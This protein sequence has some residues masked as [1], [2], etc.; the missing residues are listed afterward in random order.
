M[1]LLPIAYKWNRP[2]S[3]WTFAADIQNVT[4]HINP[5]FKE[6]NPNTDRI[7]QVSQIGIVPA[8]IIRVNF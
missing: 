3:T 8:G 2:R 7:E 4:N 6:Y 1:Y 5:F